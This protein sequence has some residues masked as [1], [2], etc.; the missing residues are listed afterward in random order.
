MAK[1]A[2]SKTKAEAIAET[3][4]K[5]RKFYPG[6]K[7]LPVRLLK[8]TLLPLSFVVVTVVMAVTY[9]PLGLEGSGSPA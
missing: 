9:L 4:K 3:K 1:G 8:A 6:H 2:A 5:N 7:T